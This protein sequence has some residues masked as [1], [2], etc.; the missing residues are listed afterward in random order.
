[1]KAEQTSPSV[2]SLPTPDAY[3]FIPLRME[4]L[5]IFCG[6]KDCCRKYKKKGKKRCK[7]CPDVN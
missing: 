1:M 5:T 3:P 6:K 7:K 2:H 4:G